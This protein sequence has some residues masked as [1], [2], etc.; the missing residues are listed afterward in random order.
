MQDG[1]VIPASGFPRD[2]G[3]ETSDNSD[4]VQTVHL[5]QHAFVH[6]RSSRVIPSKRA[7][8]GGTSSERCR[9]SRRSRDVVEV[10]VLVS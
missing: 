5:I 3:M 2:G 7:F 10:V 6:G 4:T 1:G 8:R 9:G